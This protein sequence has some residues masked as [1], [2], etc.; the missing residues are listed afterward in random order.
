[1][2]ALLCSLLFIVPLFYK[3]VIKGSFA[4]VDCLNCGRA[5]RSKD[6]VRKYDWADIGGISTKIEIHYEIANCGKCANAHSQIIQ[7]PKPK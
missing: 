1:M 3:I 7:N 6:L 2:D 4:A 5:F